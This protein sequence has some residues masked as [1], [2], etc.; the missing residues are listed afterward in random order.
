MHPSWRKRFYLAC[1]AMILLC[2]GDPHVLSATN[3]PSTPNP[4]VRAADSAAGDQKNHSRIT[5][6]SVSG[7]EQVGNFGGIAYSRTWGSVSG[8]VD[9]REN[10]HGLGTLPHDA[11]GNFHYTSEFE[12]IAPVAPNTNSVIFV[13]AENRGVPVFLNSLLGIAARGAPSAATYA[14]GFGNGF[15]F[16]HATSYARVQWQTG[17]AASVPMQAEGVG[18]VILRDFA[19]MLSGRTEFTATGKYDPGAYR[20]VILGGIS[21]S[22]FF[23]NTFLAEG[24]NADPVKG[25]AVFGG[26]IA[27]DGAGNWLAL[28][29]LAAANGSAEFPY[30]VP[31]AMPIG[32]SALLSRP[33]SD[34]FYIDIANYTD[35]FRL[36]ASLTDR[37]ALPERMRRYDW[38][39]PHAAPPFDQNAFRARASRCNGGVLVDLNPISYAPYLRAVTLGLEREL[40]VPTASGAPVLPPTTLFKLGPAPASSENFN[41]LPGTA[42][43]VPLTD[44][45]DQPV[46]GVRFPEVEHPFGRP[47]PVSL[48]PVATSSIDATCGNLGQWQQFTDAVLTRRYGSVENYLKLYAESLDRLIAKG[49]LLESDREEM[50][51]TAA[52]LYTRRAIH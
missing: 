29:Q 1:V 32:A 38:P 39:S 37:A 13:E 45:D 21:L 24:F 48:P 34:P 46:G 50:L 28:N 16:E 17:I 23:V 12:I 51:K 27:V 33:A 41:P 6:I 35:F 4:D 40:G 47:T 43:E 15:L 26:A 49:Y 8:F 20:A 22:G 19:R 25:D 14:E 7:S 42:L 5:T 36:R 11:S 2:A 52:L 18:E 44:A 10:V 3:R 31:N 30:V 9:P